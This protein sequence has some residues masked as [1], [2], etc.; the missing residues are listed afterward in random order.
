[1]YSVWIVLLQTTG[2]ASVM[3]ERNRSCE[4]SGLYL[5]PFLNTDKPLFG[6]FPQ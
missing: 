6:G 1:M 4:G 2:P 3:E 5:Y